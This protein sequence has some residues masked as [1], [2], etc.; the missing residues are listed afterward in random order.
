YASQV[1]PAWLGCLPIKD[2][3][4]EAKVVHDQLCSMVERSDAQVL[5]PH[6][7][8]LPKIVSIFAEVLC[9]GKEL[10]TDET[11]TRMISVLKR[12]Q[13]TLPPDFLASTFST[14]QPQQQLMLQSILST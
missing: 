9:N 1:I 6:S 11:T 13:Q 8:Y 10:A 2:D 4:I 5:G 3:K 12:F 14:L 7:Q